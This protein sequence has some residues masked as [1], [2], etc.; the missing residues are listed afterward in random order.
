MI[1]E[2]FYLRSDKEIGKNSNYSR[3][4]TIN[5]DKQ[6]MF[7]R[8]GVTVHH[9]PVSNRGIVGKKKGKSKKNIITNPKYLLS[10]FHTWYV[11]ARNIC[12]NR[13]LLF[14][15]DLYAFA[16][17]DRSNIARSRDINEL[18]YFVTAPLFTVSLPEARTIPDSQH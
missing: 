13:E 8:N 4:P 18:D 7:N 5:S 9:L 2:Q 1:C 3:Y 6:C 17:I 12:N 14:G 16:L 11:T 10:I 15:P